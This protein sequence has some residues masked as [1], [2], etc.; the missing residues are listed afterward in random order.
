MPKHVLFTEAT[1]I[2]VTPSGRP[3]KFLMTEMAVKALSEA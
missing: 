1:D 2:P 3:R